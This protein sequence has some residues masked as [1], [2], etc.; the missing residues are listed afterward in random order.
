[1]VQI[2]PSSSTE[3]QFL[4]SLYSLNQLI[5]IRQSQVSQ[6]AGEDKIKSRISNETVP[7]PF[8]LP[9]T[10]HCMSCNVLLMS[11]SSLRAFLRINNYR[12]VRVSAKSESS[13]KES[14]ENEDAVWWKF[15]YIYGKIKVQVCMQIRGLCW[16][17]F[18]MCRPIVQDWSSSEGFTVAGKGSDLSRVETTLHYTNIYFSFG[19]VAT[20]IGPYF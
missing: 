4:P 7:S 15:T 17:L 3:T 9:S 18:V 11:A 2:R 12:G 1:M 10:A 5:L 14:G 20:H 19:A 16:Q 6:Q 8:L 13:Q